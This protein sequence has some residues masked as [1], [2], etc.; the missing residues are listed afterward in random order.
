[1]TD[2]SI[3]A[4]TLL[5]IGLAVTPGPD[6]ILV[7]GYALKSG[8]RAA[9][10]AVMG[11]TVGGLWY[12][13]LCG[14]GFLSL[15]TAYP[16]LYVVAKIVGAIYLAWLGVRLIHGAVRGTPAI[17]NA[18]GGAPQ[19]RPFLQGFL[20]TVLNPKVALFFLAI[21]P[22]FVGAGANAPFR[23]MLLI[24]ISYLLGLVWLSAVTLVVSG[25]GHVARQ[26]NVLRW[27]EGALGVAFVGF[28]G[29]LAFE[30]N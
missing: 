9:L 22:Q 3:L 17:A 19:G 6:T 2:H 28:A 25:A 14:F 5:S 1:M 20:T 30:R 12:M 16:T 18:D 13:A 29:R 24:A 10:A 27:I 11:G 26:T 21:L 23:G 7:V 4:W 8:R 15:L